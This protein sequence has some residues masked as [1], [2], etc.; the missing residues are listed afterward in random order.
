MRVFLGGFIFCSLLVISCQKELKIEL[1]ENEQKLYAIS[2]GNPVLELDTLTEITS[3]ALIFNFSSKIVEGLFS[4]VGSQEQVYFSIKHG[5]ILY[6]CRFLNS[7]SAHFRSVDEIEVLV[8][9]Y[10]EVYLENEKIHLDSLQELIL[11]ARHQREGFSTRYYEEFNVI[12]DSRAST[13]VVSRVFSNMYLAMKTAYEEKSID[14]FKKAICEL[15]SIELIKLNPKNFGFVFEKPIPPPP[16]PPPLPKI[17]FEAEDE[18]IEFESA[19]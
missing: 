16:P 19:I 15:D 7:F 8:N 12:W 17:D 5:D 11:K 3:D 13:E 6:K 4:S 2:P 14:L 1:C 10:D 18:I 9:L